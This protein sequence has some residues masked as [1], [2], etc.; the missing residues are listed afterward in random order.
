MQE[1]QEFG[2]DDL[3]EIALDVIEDEVQIK[4]VLGFDDFLELDYIGVFELVEEYYFAVGALGIG[5][6]LESVETLC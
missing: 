2:P 6:V 3:V 1:V 4:L 5:G